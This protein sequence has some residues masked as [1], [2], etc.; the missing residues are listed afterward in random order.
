MM[1][2]ARLRKAITVNQFNTLSLVE[3]GLILNKEK[4]G[5]KDISFSELDKIY[6]KKKKLHPKIELFIICLP[7]LLTY[8]I[9][10][11]APFEMLIIASAFTFFPVFIA[12]H[13]Y[14]WYVLKLHLKDGTSFNK[15]VS[16]HLKSE[17]VRIINVVNNEHSYYK[18]NRWASK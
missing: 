9:L 6:I 17:S 1:T 13:K 4:K 2:I 8:L 16:I 12:V 3:N 18:A 10:Q 15:R 5:E 11:Y 7:F 14:K